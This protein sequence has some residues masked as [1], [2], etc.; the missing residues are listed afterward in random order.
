MNEHAEDPVGQASSKVVQYVSLATMAAEAIAQVRQQRAA[1]AA[2]TDARAA[3]ALRAEYGAA[4]GAARTQWAP[5]LDRRLRDQTSS[6]TPGWRGPRR[7]PGWTPTPR[8]GS[9]ASGPRS[10]CACFARTS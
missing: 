10:G 4:L 6:P 9:P 2:T 8:P 1:A 7:R 5:V 3:A